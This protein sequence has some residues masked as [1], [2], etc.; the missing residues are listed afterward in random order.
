VRKCAAHT[1]VGAGL[2]LFWHIGCGVS[3]SIYTCQNSSNCCKYIINKLENR[4][5]FC[6][7]EMVQSIAVLSVGK[8]LTYQLPEGC[9]G[10]TKYD[11]SG[12]FTQ[13]CL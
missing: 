5:N 3:I 10:P 8:Q 13:I 7:I 2:S 4:K 1:R 9:F 6:Q 12:T 11:N